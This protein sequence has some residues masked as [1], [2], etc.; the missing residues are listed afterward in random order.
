MRDIDPAALLAGCAAAFAGSLLLCEAIRRYALRTALLDRPNERSSHRVP[1]PR[2]GG[3]AF[4]L[5][6]TAALPLL[7]VLWPDRS[8]LWAA[9]AGGLLVAIPGWIDDRGS[10]SPGRRLLAQSLAA[11]WALFCLG[12]AGELELG[13]ARIPLGLAGDLTAFLA[14]LWSVNLFNFMDG[15]DGL[16]GTEA[17][18]AAL[19]GALW[20]GRAGDPAGAAACALLAAATA[21]FLV[22]NLPPAR[23]F[24]GDV[25]SG[26]LGYVL[27]VLAL[28]S[29]NGGSA[30]P[31][32]WLL[33]LSA[34]AV[35]ATAT[36]AD[37]LRGGHSP[38]AAH[39]EHAYQRLVRSG[40]SHGRV[41]GGFGVLN[42]LLGALALAL[43]GHPAALAA[44]VPCTWAALFALW[45]R[46]R[47]LRTD[48]EIRR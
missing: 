32:L 2:G 27:A 24:M 43:Q 29:N 39:R 13:F 6:L 38:V 23:I 44:A 11:L 17:V 46:T 1:T 14:I 7:R 48:R 41:T 34:F 19:F 3:A 21:G 47:S 9:L 20:L 5:L 8:S 4:V 15:I 22:R 28:A 18:C 37:R 25:G 45:L 16:A 30:P 26:W 35:D 12:G 36:L 33:L 10:L 42:L 40:L 31:T